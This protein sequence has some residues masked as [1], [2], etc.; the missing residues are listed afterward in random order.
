MVF[1][2]ST[3]NNGKTPPAVE[4]RSVIEYVLYTDQD[5]SGNFDTIRFRLYMASG[6]KS[7]LDSPLV[8]MTIAAIP[9]SSH[10]LVFRKTVPAAYDQEKLA[11]GFLYQ[12]DNVGNSWLLD[13]SEVGEIF[14]RV[15]YN[16][17]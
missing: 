4:R 7:L 14:K 10:A 17:R 13:S 15:V 8:A 12:I 6:S 9:D 16:F 2:H 1:V 3:N 11:V 5:F